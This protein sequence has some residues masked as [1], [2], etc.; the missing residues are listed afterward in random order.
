MRQSPRGRNECNNNWQRSQHP[1]HDISPL[2]SQSKHQVQ[3]FNPH[4]PQSSFHQSRTTCNVTH[5]QRDVVAFVE[6][7][8]AHQS[9]L[10]APPNALTLD[11]VVQAICHHFRVNAFEELMDIRALQLP[12][13]KQLHTVNQ[14]L[15]YNM[16]GYGLSTNSRLVTPFF[17]LKQYN[18]FIARP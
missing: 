9:N 8:R 4:H 1:Q 6:T 13:L 5:M 16:K 12:I 18:I 15:F 7:F 11:I 14:R 2:P 10:T 17:T 3:S